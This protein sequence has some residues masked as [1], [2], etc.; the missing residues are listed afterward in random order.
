MLRIS[1]IEKAL[2][3]DLR[4]TARDHPFLVIAVGTF[5]GYYLGRNHG[6]TILSALI[7][8]GIAAG[9]STARRMLGVEP[10][11]RLARAR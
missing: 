7:S 11:P 6:R 9:T 5:A 3:D 2:P 4:R 1:A 8:L 10:S